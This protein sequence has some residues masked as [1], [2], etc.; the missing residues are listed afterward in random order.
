MMAVAALYLLPR[1]TYVA[2]QY[3]IFD[4]NVFKNIQGNAPNWGTAGQRFSALVSRALALTV[5]AGTLIVGFAQRRHFGRVLAPVALAFAPMGSL[6]LMSYGGEAI[7]RVFAF[8]LPWCTFVLAAA[9]MRLVRRDV[10][11]AVVT[12]VLLTLFTLAA[13]QGLQGQFSV[14]A[15][16]AEEWAAARVLETEMPPGA[17]LVLAARNF[18]TRSTANYTQFN[19]GRP[20][21]PALLDERR[22]RGV[23][24]GSQNLDKVTDYVRSL[25]GTRQYLVVSRQMS[26][27]ADYFGYLPPGSLTGLRAALRR[28]PD[29]RVVRD[30]PQV[31]VYQIANSS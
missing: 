31:G 12:G 15:V 13:Q 10:V 28:S 14:N 11:S 25:G 24:F 17:T 26:V 18:P 5:W 30:D 7:Y 27:Y 4:L 8:S 20:T 22:F 16:P 9:W 3:Q 29:W 1:Y 6:F 23:A 21:D 19:V 2:N